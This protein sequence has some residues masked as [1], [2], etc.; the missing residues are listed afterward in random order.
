MVV[1]MPA[2][3]AL[4]FLLVI[5]A[6]SAGA[7]LL[8]A[9]LTNGQSYTAGMVYGACIGLCISSVE[10]GLVFGDI[11]QRAR[12]WPTWLYIPVCEAASVVLVALGF[13]LGGA[14]SWTTGLLP[15]PFLEATVPSLR[16]MIYA[17][18]VA[19]ALVFVT[20]V[21][22][23]LGRE[24]FKSLLTGRYH[25]PV[26]E[27]RIFL[28]LDLVGS[29]AY[30]RQHGDLRAQEF[31][32]AVFA[33]IAEPI[34]RH[35]GTIEDYVGDMAMITWPEARGLHDARC[36]CCVF[37]IQQVFAEQEGEWRRR[38]GQVP[39]FRAALHGGPVVT[40][41]IGIDRH[42][43]SYFGDVVNTTGRLESL[44][45]QLG[46]SVLI[47]ADL[48]R[49][50]PA[51]PRYVQPRPH[52]SHMLHGREQPLEVFAIEQIAKPDTQVA[53][54]AAATAPWAKRYA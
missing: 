10:R 39:T 19:A 52:G 28:F 25:R 6:L 3:R 32:G 12:R 7:G 15:V 50:C 23:L 29:T 44:A 34:E 17:L 49:R 14:V 42:K 24:V 40:A 51:L 33:A 47:S 27:R 37:A 21:R 4:S 8:Y 26:E 30:A 31:L 13:A 1:A 18:I 46:V 35:S 2:G 54:V 9:A 22:D 16:I 36:I 43:I 38:Y 41:E 45:R 53:G 48:L 11:L 5:V 20:R